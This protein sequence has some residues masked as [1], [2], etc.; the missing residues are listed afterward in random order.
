MCQPPALLQRAVRQLTLPF[1]FAG[2][3]LLLLLLLTKPAVADE[4]TVPDVPGSISGKVTDANGVPLADIDVTLYSAGTYPDYWYAQRVVRTA[5]DG[6]YRIGLLPAGIYHVGFSDPAQQLADSYYNGAPTVQQATD[7]PI[8]GTNSSG[9]DG[10]LTAGSMIT[11]VVIFPNSAQPFNLNALGN[12]RILR[13]VRGQWLE[14]KTAIL[15]NSFPTVTFAVGGLAAGT[16]RLCVVANFFFG[17]EQPWDECY[18][19]VATGVDQATDITLAVGETRPNINIILGDGANFAKL[20]GRVTTTTGD[21]LNKI[22]ITAFI[23]VT[24][25]YGDYWR[26]AAFTQTNLA[27]DYHFRNLQ[28]GTYTLL[29]ADLQDKYVD[30]FYNHEPTLLES[31][32]PTAT[33]T[34]L[35]APYEIRATVNATL[36][37]ASQIVGAVTV[38][39]EGPPAR[40]DVQLFQQQ[41]TTWHF[42]RNWSTDGRGRFQIGGLLPGVY[43]VSANTDIGG[44]FYGGYHGGTNFDQAAVITFTAPATYTN[45]DIELTNF[46]GVVPYAGLLGGRVTANGQPAPNIK[47]TAYLFYNYPYFSPHVYVFTDG[48]GRYR[49]DGLLPNRYYLSF[50]DPGGTYATNWYNARG[51]PALWPGEDLSLYENTAVTNI[52]ASL[53]PGGGINGSVFVRDPNALPNIRFYRK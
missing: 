4:P 39:G 23:S 42:I 47:V 11:G 22:A 33:T 38:V 28:P 19:N 43:K 2:L 49:I 46:S 30:A 1:A 8:A 41:A 7:V 52:N 12:M 32:P 3:S 16:Y 20:G 53:V 51:Q 18:D 31:Y 48:D 45:A 9:I 40:A 36:T 21:P 29:F 34:I 26:Q 13:K 14:V 5:S 24:S 10:I 15:A 6:T 44:S 37:L 35:L 27:G 25:G 17:F 50:S